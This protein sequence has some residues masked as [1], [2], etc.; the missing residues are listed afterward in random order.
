[1]MNGSTTTNTPIDSVVSRTDTGLVSV[2]LNRPV[3]LDLIFPKQYET[4]DEPWPVLYLN[5]GQDLERLRMRHVL[6]SVY[7]QQTVRPF[8]L[9]AVHA[10]DRIQEYGVA[11]QAD[12]L[13][14]GAKAGAYTDFV[15]HELLPYVQKH[16]RVS[17]QPEQAV[18]A[19]FSLGGLSAFDLVWNHPDRFQK[20]GVF[21]GSFWW[22]QRGLNEGYSD[23][24]R[25]MHAQVRKTQPPKGSAFWFQTGT[26]DE[27]DDR[28]NDGIIDSIDDTLDLIAELER[29]GFRWGRNVTYVEVKDGRH[30]PETWS[31]VMPQFLSWA[32]PRA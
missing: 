24:D 30:E 10:G 13:H 25:I 20:A 27:T 31:Q 26:L 14:R 1:M 7:A 9:V 5:D 4:S 11:A 29:K 6:A 23:A 2:Y 8:V 18:F 22:R 28:D 19:G 15:I 32:F 17:Q 16:Y 21:S 12:Y 3:R